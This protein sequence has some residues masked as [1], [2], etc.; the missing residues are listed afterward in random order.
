MS[1][2]TPNLKQHLV[3]FITGTGIVIDGV[4]NNTTTTGPWT[5]TVPPYVT[6][7]YVTGCGAGGGG[8]GGYDASVSRAGAGGG[9]A[10]ATF[11]NAS[12]PVVPFSP[13]TVTVG[14]GG[15]GGAAN[16]NGNV[17]GATSIGGL[18]SY[19]PY[20]ITSGSVSGELDLLPGG[21]GFRGTDLQSGEGGWSGV[22]P[23]LVTA[24]MK[25]TVG[26]SVN[27]ATPVQPSSTTPIT[28]SAA[29]YDQRHS[30]GCPGGGASTAGTTAGT[31]GG[32]F[33]GTTRPYGLGTRGTGTTV[34]GTSYGGGGEGGMSPFGFFGNGGNGNAVGSNAT[35][36][37]A[38]G[39]G[40]GGN[41][42]GGNGANGYI[43]FVYWSYE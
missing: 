4:I 1:L 39:G 43:S 35:G 24:L 18:A 8:G 7:L 6:A 17:G 42:A 38:G 41:A 27:A 36:Y 31:N 28:S 13:L 9:G 15:S 21:G 16:T 14:Q 12:V 23:D 20:T 40:G 25:P 11:I 10:G 2:G 3:E 32:L 26:A 29:G 19:N 33:N 5:W 34:A 37:G 30:P 22:F